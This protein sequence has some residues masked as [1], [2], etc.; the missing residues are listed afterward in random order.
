MALF[1]AL[2]DQ[3]LGEAR[4]TRDAIT[5]ITEPECKILS[6]SDGQGCRGGCDCDGHPGMEGIRVVP[7]ETTGMLSGCSDRVE[8][9]EGQE[10]SQ[11]EQDKGSVAETVSEVEVPE[12]A[13]GTPPTILTCAG[14]DAAATA[15][16]AAAASGP[17]IGLT[18]AMIDSETAVELGQGSQQHGGIVIGRPPKHSSLDSDGQV[19]QSDHVNGTCGTQQSL[20]LVE[21][22][23]PA[24]TDSSVKDAKGSDCNG[25]GQLAAAGGNTGAP[26]PEAPGPKA[27]EPEPEA[28]QVQEQLSQQPSGPQRQPSSSPKKEA[29]ASIAEPASSRIASSIL[30]GYEWH[31]HAVKVLAA[32]SG[33]DDDDSDPSELEHVLKMAAGDTMS[34]AFSGIEAPHTASCANRLAMSRVLGREVPMPRLLHMIEYDPQNQQE[35]LLLSKQTGNHAC[36]F[37]DIASFYRPELGDVLAELKQKPMLCVEILGPLIASGRAVKSSA[38]CL[39][40]QKMCC[41]RTAKRH[42]AGTSCTPYSRRGAGLGLMDFATV[43][44]LC[45]IALRLLLQEPDVTNELLGLGSD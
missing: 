41:L 38:F 23:V 25:P 6:S 39:T 44:S 30:E 22:V 21:A 11:P 4:R 1:V 28:P 43:H 12:D 26:E 8:G 16:A 34:T 14:A 18:I 32:A 24:P 33:D 36:L 9:G 42:I 31:D 29:A 37:G 35:L 40:H 10:E 17:N 2:Q 19:I 3:L 7:S 13:E 20:A 15:T 45:W 27:P 5:A